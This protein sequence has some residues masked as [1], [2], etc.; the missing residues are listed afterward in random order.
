MNRGSGA[1]VIHSLRRIRGMV[2]GLGALL[3]GFQFLLTQVASYMLRRSAFSELSSLM[4][5]FMRT[6]LGPESLAF[7]SFTGIVAFGYFHPV[8]I[9]AALTIA[10]WIATE[11]AGE[12]ETRFVD[13]TLARELT[14]FDVVMRSAIVFVVAGAVVLGLMTIG[15]WTGLT[16][17]TPA[18]APRP[19]A[20]LVLSLAISLGTLMVCWGGVGFAVAAVSRRRAVAAGVTGGGALAAYLLDYL[21][22]AWE[23]ARTIGSMTPFHFFEPMTLITGAPLSIRNVIMLIAIGLI[24]T[25]V[26]GV[27]FSHRDI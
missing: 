3:G 8:V 12:I 26:G 22:R 1:L 7:M 14:R 2:I 24:G 13:L 15:T 6:V 11:P 17:C 20:R 9:A 25:I 19:G 21:G 5:D 18:E 10:I 23:P 27:I 4:P 16:C